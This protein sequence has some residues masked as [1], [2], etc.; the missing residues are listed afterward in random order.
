MASYFVTGGD[1]GETM[2][3]AMMF[4]NDPST[5]WHQKD[6]NFEMAG[7]GVSI[8]FFNPIMFSKMSILTRHD[9]FN[10]K[11]KKV[12][13]YIDDDEKF[14]TPDDYLPAIGDQID[15]PP[16]SKPTSGKK[17]E[18]RFTDT[19][20]AQIAELWIVYNDIPAEFTGFYFLL[21]FFYTSG[22]GEVQNYCRYKKPKITFFAAFESLNFSEQ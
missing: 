19:N 22:P 15:F 16:T 14:C 12:C 4:D 10:T 7:K 20:H 6:G 13:L 3:P 8:T 17:F 18:L 21:M 11:Y 2:K 1:N 9:G 5:M